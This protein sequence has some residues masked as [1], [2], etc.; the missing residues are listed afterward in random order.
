MGRGITP[1]ERIRRPRPGRAMAAALVLLG[2]VAAAASLATATPVRAD[3]STVSVTIGRTGWDS[4]E[5]GLAPATVSGSSFGQLYSTPVNGQVFA[6]PLVAG[7]TV[8]VATETNHVYGINA[9]T[10]AIIWTRALGTPWPSSADNCPNPGPNIGTTSTPVYDSTTGTVYLTSK[11][12]D[13]A[14]V[15]HPHYYLHALNAS[16]GAERTGWPVTLQGT[17]TNSPGHPFNA[18]TS[19]QRPGLLLMGGSVYFGFASLCDNGPYVG[20]VMGVNTTSRKLTMWSSEAGSST[21]EAGIWMSGGGLVSDGAGRIFV[22]TGNGA[23]TGASPVK[24]PGSRP[25]AGLGESVVRLGVNTDGSLSAKDFF[26]PTNNTTMD[27]NDT[28][29]GSGGPASLPSSLFGTPAHPHLMVEV[30]KDGRILMLNRDNLG[31]QGQG[32]GGTDNVLSV[33]GPFKGVW[34]HP[35]V[36]GGNGGYVYTVETYGQLRALKYSVT[37]SGVPTLTSVAT[38][39]EGFGYGSG[40]PVVTSNNNSGSALVWSIWSGSG[41]DG[42]GAELRVYNAVPVNGSMQLLRSFPIVTATRFSVPATDSGRVYVGTKDGHLIAFGV[43]ATTG[44]TVPNPAPAAPVATSPSPSAPAGT[45]PCPPT[46][47]LPGFRR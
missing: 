8:V 22:A 37:S 16:S 43:Q 30:G 23:G 25:P 36:W 21:G 44:A 33:A 6:Q 9:A 20:T 31:G 42:Q 45:D 28:D 4:H 18:F 47:R 41:A 24:G 13:G 7:P 10:G 35:G 26:S 5:P 14:D 38:S 1:S 11:V 27:V 17:P 3:V 40:S 15:Q 29:L 32:P 34:G 39:A 12:N 2:S 19:L 46:V